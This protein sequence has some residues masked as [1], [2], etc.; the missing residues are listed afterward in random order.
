LTIFATPLTAQPQQAEAGIGRQLL[1][2]HLARQA[3]SFRHRHHRRYVYIAPVVRQPQASERSA[4]RTPTRNYKSAGPAAAAAAAAAA[5]QDANGRIYDAASMAWYD[6]GNQCWTGT[7]PWTFKSGNWYYGGSRWYR[8]GADW[9]SDIADPPAP[10]ACHTVP[11]FAKVQ[12]AQPATHAQPRREGLEGAVA[13]NGR[14]DPE[15]QA[16]RLEPVSTKSIK[17]APAADRPAA[18]CKKYFASI[19]DLVTVPCEG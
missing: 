4:A 15:Q 13:Q 11:A 19:G 18:L 9:R 2:I 7:Q 12:P 14:R 1:R 8:S 10:V 6:G 16:E 17:A 3:H 5:A